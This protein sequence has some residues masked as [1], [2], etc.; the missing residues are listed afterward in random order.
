VSSYFAETYRCGQSLTNLPSS[1][2]WAIAQA[3]SQI[4]RSGT[5]AIDASF[6][7]ARLTYQQLRNGAQ[8]FCKYAFV[9]IAYSNKTFTNHELF[10]ALALCS[11]LRIEMTEGEPLLLGDT[12]TSGDIDTQERWLRHLWPEAFFLDLNNES[13][14]W[15]LTH[16]SLIDYVEKDSAF[17]WDRTGG[18]AAILHLCLSLMGYQPLPIKIEDLI[19]SPEH[20]V[21]VYARHYW[22]RMVHGARVNTDSYDSKAIQALRS[23]FGFLTKGSPTYQRWLGEIILDVDR[24]WPAG[25][26]F[27]QDVVKALQD[28]APIAAMCHASLFGFLEAWLNEP[29]L[30]I[31]ELNTDVLADVGE[32]AYLDDRAIDIGRR[33]L[34]LGVDVNQSLKRRVGS[35][36][37]SALAH[38]VR[39]STSGWV[40]LLLSQG[41]DISSDLSG[42]ASAMI[43]AVAK[44]QHRTV[45]LLLTRGLTPDA[46]L[47]DDSAQSALLA[48]SGNGDLEM[49]EKLVRAGADVNRRL[50]GDAVASALAAAALNEDAVPVLELLINSGASI[51]MQGGDYGSP[52]AAACAVD[53]IEAATLLIAHGADV[54][55]AI[56]TRRF[57][58]ALIAAASNNCQRC[59]RVLIRAGAHI[60]QDT[61]KGEYKSA[62]I[63]AASNGSLDC[64]LDII[65]AGADENRAISAETFSNSITAAAGEGHLGCLRALVDTAANRSHVSPSLDRG[66]AS[67]LLAAASNG[68]SDCLEALIEYGANADG[69]MALFNAMYG[70][71]VKCIHILLQTG[72]DVNQ[73]IRDGIYGSALGI[74]AGSGNREV[75][76]ALISAGADVNIVHQPPAEYGTPLIAAVARRKFTCIGPLARAGAIVD[77]EVSVGNFSTALA[78]NVWVTPYS[79]PCLEL[80][81]QAGANLDA[82]VAFFGERP[83]DTALIA[84]A[85]LGRH[86]CARYLVKEG[87]DAKLRIQGGRFRDAMEAA[88]T[89]V[90]AEDA[91]IFDTSVVIWPGVIPS[92]GLVKDKETIVELLRQHSG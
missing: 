59:L 24:G 38:A 35:R 10:R 45:E 31:S 58:S 56:S 13:S 51:H 87:A 52:L 60:D 43:A 40:E 67:A 19:P 78:A 6:H 32:C 25:S 33:L 30:D 91:N 3:R 21:S 86:M 4:G 81:A 41:A 50:A 83:F 27:T 42:V 66:L 2:L 72:V 88:M 16:K 73:P 37:H 48:A 62:L 55:Q 76:E 49:V 79:Q 17:N 63:A 8:T 22:P 70:G 71:S 11:F 85:Y 69:E 84:A 12:V 80:L 23:F 54:N 26:Y 57:G 82:P 75:L 65:N 14:E 64:L 77:R 89:A 28:R 47:A 36:S 46:G 18:S 44:R 7:N 34:D 61:D 1:F 39:E 92:K 68:R 15:K 29:N 53:N 90:T 9:L 74:A 5:E 20:P